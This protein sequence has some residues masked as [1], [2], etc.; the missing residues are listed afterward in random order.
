VPLRIGGPAGDPDRWEPGWTHGV[1]AA[2]LEG[3]KQGPAN[4]LAQRR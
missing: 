1:R 2:I 3:D 4:R